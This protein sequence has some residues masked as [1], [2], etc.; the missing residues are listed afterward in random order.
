MQQQQRLDLPPLLSG[1]TF[2]EAYEL[3]LLVDNRERQGAQQGLGQLLASLRERGVA[4]EARHLPVGDAL[5]VARARCV[6]GCTA[7]GW[8]VVSSLY[9]CTHTSSTTAR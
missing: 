1:Q 7:A 4:A 2:V 6:A 3:V 5:W 9:E 8:V